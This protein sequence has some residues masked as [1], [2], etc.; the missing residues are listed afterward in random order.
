[1]AVKKI[2]W[3]GVLAIVDTQFFRGQIGALY[4]SNTA[5]STLHLRGLP[6]WS[7]LFTTFTSQ[8]SQ[9]GT[10]HNHAKIAILNTEM[11]GQDS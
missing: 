2:D 5:K 3:C 7:M 4:V 1:M 8:Y 10:T 6:D 11:E 9:Y